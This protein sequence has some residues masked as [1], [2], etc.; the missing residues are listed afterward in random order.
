[1]V[2]SYISAF[3]F[4][5]IVFLSVLIDLKTHKNEEPVTLMN[6]TIWSIVWVLVSFCFAGYLGWEYGLDKASLFLSGYLV[7]KSL[8]VDNLFVFM[9]IFSSFS[10]KSAFQHRILYYGILGAMVLRMLFVFAGTSL[11]FLGQWVLALFGLFVLWSAYQMYRLQGAEDGEDDIDYNLHWSVQLTKKYFPI[12]P[13]L[14]GHKF[15]TKQNGKT[16]LT[17]LFLCLVVIEISD[18]MFAFDSVPAVI[19]ITQE[20]FLIY[21]SNIFAIL[22]LRSMFF[23]LEAAKQY[24]CHLEKAVILILVFIGVKMLLGIEG[25]YHIPTNISLMIISGTLIAGI[26]ASYI[27]PEKEE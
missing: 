8:S 23:V 11:L 16:M 21:T 27:F 25:F 26:V 20:P 12:H 14:D 13:F 22:G 18:V 6:A 2:F 3:V 7:E 10:I 5:G 24:L 4:L 17:P 15:F 1:M 19:A 9:A